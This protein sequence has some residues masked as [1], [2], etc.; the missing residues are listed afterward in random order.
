M[1]KLLFSAALAVSLVAGSAQAQA[2]AIPGA[3][4]AVVDLERVTS[5]CNACKSAR[6]TSGLLMTT[7]SLSASSSAGKSQPKLAASV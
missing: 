4:V 7:R 5:L 1:N 3:V 2:Q 6:V